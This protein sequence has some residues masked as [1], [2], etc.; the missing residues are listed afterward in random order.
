MNTTPSCAAAQALVAANLVGTVPKTPN[1]KG[2]KKTG[3]IFL[4]PALLQISK[5]S[6]LTV[7]SRQRKYDSSKPK[8]M[9]ETP[10]DTFILLI[11]SVSKT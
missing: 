7:S 8:A 6:F 11:L 2:I 5:F 3:E 4:P 9:K 1:L 10:I